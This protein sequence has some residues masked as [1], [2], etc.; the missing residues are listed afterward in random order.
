L[1]RINKELK[2]QSAS[3]LNSL[4]KEKDIL[5][6]YVHCLILKVDAE[7]RKKVSREKL[8]DELVGALCAEIGKLQQIEEIRFELNEQSN[9]FAD[10]ISAAA[11]RLEQMQDSFN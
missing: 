6:K 5:Q 7:K 2:K 1:K 9:S 8:T 3:E 10:M 4:R 11:E